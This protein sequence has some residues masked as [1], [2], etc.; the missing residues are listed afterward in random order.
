M[1]ETNALELVGV[2]KLYGRTAA[3]RSTSLHVAPGEIL[4]LLGPNGSGKTTLLK[5]VAGAISPSLGTGTI[6]GLDMVRDRLTL[7][8]QVGLLAN[9]TYLY[10][11]LSAQENLRFIVTMAGRRADAEAIAHAL[12]R[13][14]LARHGTDRVRNF[15]SGMKRRLG[16]ARL[17]LLGH[18][19]LLLDEPYNSLDAAGADLVD[20]V[21]RSLTAAGG[22]TILATHDAERALSLA[23]AVAVLDQG[24]L[25][26]F[27]PA[28][29]YSVQRAQYVG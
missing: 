12:E 3:L 29:G 21:V 22:T 10:D 1:S 7:R 25:S 4:A 9:E 5:I 6:F 27:G 16:L 18:Q 26:Y 11:D 8:G 28:Q 2:A 17:L 19:L 15:S 13:V 24:K 14:G 23:H 20:V